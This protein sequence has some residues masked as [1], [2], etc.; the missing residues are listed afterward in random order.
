MMSPIKKEPTIFNCSEEALQTGFCMF[1]DEKFEDN[2]EL[3]KQITQKIK[4]V[5]ISLKKSEE[6]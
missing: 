2:E 5:I 1:H 3:I 6:G 4:K